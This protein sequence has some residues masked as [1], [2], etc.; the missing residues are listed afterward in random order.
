MKVDVVVIVAVLLAYFLYTRYTRSTFSAFKDKID[1]YEFDNVLFSLSFRN[2][3]FAELDSKAIDYNAS[4]WCRD[5]NAFDYRNISFKKWE[6]SYKDLVLIWFVYLIII[7]LNSET[8]N[9]HA[10][11]EEQIKAL[12]FVTGLNG[13]DVS[14]TEAF[15]HKCNNILFCYEDISKKYLKFFMH[16]L[17]YPEEDMRNYVRENKKLVKG[18]E[19]EEK[20]RV[21]FS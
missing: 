3:M 4:G 12:Y 6:R 19:K 21:H 5:V 14:D 17:K 1:S 18:K 10:L 11:N 9:L 15:D 16:M 20:A 7:V 2:S 8:H 13:Y